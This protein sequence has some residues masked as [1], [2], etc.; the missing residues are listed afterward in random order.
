[1]I[2]KIKGTVQNYAQTQNMIKSQTQAWKQTFFFQK[3]LVQLH[4]CTLLPEMVNIVESGT[5]IYMIVKA[6]Y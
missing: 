3:V 5:E 2:I 1:V 4:L 6:V